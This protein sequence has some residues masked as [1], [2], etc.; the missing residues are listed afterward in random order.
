MAARS[1]VM[2]TGTH[3]LN[4]PFPHFPM[5]HFPIPS[6]PPARY[7]PRPLNGRGSRQPPRGDCGLSPHDPI[8]PPR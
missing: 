7:R 5:P 3:F 1:L 2:P 8:P 6:L 4:S